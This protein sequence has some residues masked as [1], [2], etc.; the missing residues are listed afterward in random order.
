MGAA[1]RLAST[2]LVARLLMIEDGPW[3][4][5]RRGRA[6]T[7]KLLARELARFEIRPRT[8]PVG[9]NAMPKGYFAA[10]FDDAWKRYVDL[11]PLQSATP[12]QVNKNKDLKFA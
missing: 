2:D 6:I 7:P 4:D 1:D 12:Q 11:P 10:D 8:I 5:F 3:V 9:G